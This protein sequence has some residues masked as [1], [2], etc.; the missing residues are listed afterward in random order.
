MFTNVASLLKIAGDDL[1]LLFKNS[2][3]FYVETQN[4]AALAL[5]GEPAADLNFAVIAAGPDTERCLL[6]FF[7][8]TRKLSVPCMFLVENAGDENVVVVAERA[9]LILGGTVPLMVC[10]ANLPA[11]TSPA[12][13]IRRASTTLELAGAQQ[14][15]SKTFS[16]P[17]NN[18][19]TV[20]C[21]RLMAQPDIDIFVAFR[22]EKPV[23]TVQTTRSG[24]MAGIWCMAT[25]PDHQ[26]Q[27]LGRAT[28][29][30]A[31]QQVVDRGIESF[32]LFATDA[33]RPLYQSVGF[34]TMANFTVWLSGESSQ[35]SSGH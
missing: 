31:M 21:E 16:L 9:G 34:Q 1:V 3:G 4:A 22:G 15:I 2:P 35:V 30:Y 20:F 29:L 19:E 17:L 33:G 10:E 28:L 6:K 18:V 7:E 13:T 11:V 26:R 23:C 27:G 8:T 5:S 14:L 32:Y 12:V 24:S 25:D